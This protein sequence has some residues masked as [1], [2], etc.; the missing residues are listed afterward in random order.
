MHGVSIV[1]AVHKELISPSKEILKNRDR[2]ISF[3]LEL[4]GRGTLAY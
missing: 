3:V 4:N 2:G 1:D